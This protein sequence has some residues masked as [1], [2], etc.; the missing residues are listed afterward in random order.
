MLKDKLPSMSVKD[1]LILHTIEETGYEASLVE[2]VIE[3]I[4][5][6]TKEATQDSR[7]VELSG[8][9]TLHVYPKKLERKIR[10]I[11]L[12]VD[13]NENT[14]GVDKRRE[15]AKQMIEL[16]KAKQR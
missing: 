8:F 9:G 16:L 1:H 7:D 13:R 4:T 12:W 10:N 2:S 3:W 11:Q 6:D 5:K 15:G 14:P